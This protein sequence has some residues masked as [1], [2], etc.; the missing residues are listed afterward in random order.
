[1]AAQKRKQMSFMMFAFGGAR[2]WKFGLVFLGARA[3]AL[4]LDFASSRRCAHPPPPPSPISS[5]LN[6]PLLSENKQNAPHAQ[7]PSP[8][9]ARTC[10]RRTRRWISRRSE[11]AC[12]NSFPARAPRRRPPPTLRRVPLTP[13]PP[14]TTTKNNNR[15]FNAICKHFIDTLTELKVDKQHIDDAVAVVATTKDAILKQGAYAGKA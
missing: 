3:S 10:S 7:A 15:H 4:G 8:T 5:Q 2:D 13:P 11:C 9:R 12:Y 14:T 6:L 1:M